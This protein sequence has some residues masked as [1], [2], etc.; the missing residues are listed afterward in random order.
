[1]TPAGRIGLILLG[2][3]LGAVL[4][5][6]ALQLI[7]Q[8]RQTGEPI[9]GL[10]AEQLRAWRDHPR[11]FVR[12]GDELVANHPL[13][14]PQSFPAHK[15]AGERRIFLLGGSQA[16]GDPYV[17]SISELE[18]VDLDALG[19]T[20]TGGI[21]TWLEEY[22]RLLDPQR[23]VRVVN[24]AVGS[25]DLGTVARVLA[26]IAETGS[27]DVA[28]VLSGNNESYNRKFAS[29]Q[30]FEAALA[31]LTDRFASGIE[32]ILR[33]AS[34]R[35]FDLYLATVATNLRDW[36]P[37]HEGQP[38]ASADINRFL[39]QHDWRAALRRFEEEG[40]TDH[41]LYHYFRAK[42]FE[43]EGD[44]ESAY[45]AYMRAKD[46]DY[47]LIRAHSA[48]NDLIRAAAGSH[49]NVVDLEAI[50]RTDASVRIP[51]F[52][53]FH[54]HCHFRIQ[55]NAQVAKALVQQY[56]HDEDL[57]GAELPALDVQARLRDSLR[58]LYAIK[59]SKWQRLQEVSQ[60]DYLGDRNRE[61]VRRE[62][63]AAKDDLERLGERIDLYESDLP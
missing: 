1:M 24:A 18:G 54:D 8:A 11:F 47:N 50:V 7:G 58:A 23:R 13:M 29:R 48:W 45:D 5:L 55:A 61:S 44:L 40:R 43:S 53:L 38:I 56:R 37:T 41:A 39:D 19:L 27:P 51:G 20:N 17:H 42:A 3:A 22:F 16:M 35:S 63:E 9:N 46:N 25:Q 31:E 4:G 60:F 26:E 30:E 59:E 52:D 6:I 34:T 15:P 21:A 14:P 2:T 33:I 62:F 57:T 32:E 49:A 28:I 36:V 10:D 12:R